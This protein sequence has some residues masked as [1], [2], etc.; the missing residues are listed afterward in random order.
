[1]GL[2]AGRAGVRRGAWPRGLCPVRVV[3]HS[4][5]SRLSVTEPQTS[6]HRGLVSLRPQGK[7]SMS[8]CVTD[9]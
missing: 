2:R 4:T 3:P 5:L 9:T 6:E 8:D 1:M 7:H